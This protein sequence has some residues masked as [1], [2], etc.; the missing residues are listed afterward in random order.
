MH[1]SQNHIGPYGILHLWSGIQP[2]QGLPHPSGTVYTGLRL[3]PTWP[4]HI[5]WLTT[6]LHMLLTCLI[7]WL[8]S[9]LRQPGTIIE[10]MYPPYEEP[11]LPVHPPLN[12]ESINDK[13]ST[14]SFS[15]N[16]DKKL[17]TKVFYLGTYRWLRFEGFLA[18]WGLLELYLESAPAYNFKWTPLQ[19]ILP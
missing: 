6:S 9:G 5:F 19:T 8:A 11:M 4:D 14:G 3:C 18:V 12:P 15:N 1:Y 7:F 10:L 13:K 16:G 17:M 2:M